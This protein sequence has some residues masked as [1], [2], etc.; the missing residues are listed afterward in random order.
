MCIPGSD[1]YREYI[2]TRRS[3]MSGRLIGIPLMLSVSAVFVAAAIPQA[4]T[5]Y[6]DGVSTATIC[7]QAAARCTGN[8]EPNSQETYHGCYTACMHRYDYCMKKWGGALNVGPGGPPGHPVTPILP[9]RTK[10]PPLKGTN[11]PSKPLRPV[12]TTPPPSA[13]SNNPGGGSPAGGTIFV[14][15]PHHGR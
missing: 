14:D 13:V 9:T 4:T 1:S 6:A 2:A 7:A 3:V 12:S 5:A 10:P 11:P 8:C 15:H